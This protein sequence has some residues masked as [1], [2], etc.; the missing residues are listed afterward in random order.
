MRSERLS[1]TVF[2][3][4]RY[5]TQ[6]TL[7]Q[8][9]IIIKAIDDLTHILKGRKNVKGD[10]QI[11]ALEKIDELLN[12][13]L[14]KISTVKEKHVTP[15]ENT[16]P[17]AR[18]AKEAAI[19][20]KPIPVQTPIP[21]VQKNTNIEITTISPLT[22]R[23]HRKSKEDISPKQMNLRHRIREATQARLPH[24]HNMQLRQ[25]EQREHVQLIRDNKTGEYLNYRQLI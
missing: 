19:V 6:P 4:H 21:R 3:K 22:P 10:A 11:E 16:Q 13:I 24:R 9:D 23:V 18:L 2:F 1:D 20:D 15:N 17:T 8:A 7:T 25:Q 12:N 5:I 14:K